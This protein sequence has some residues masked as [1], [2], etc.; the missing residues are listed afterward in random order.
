MLYFCVIIGISGTYKVNLEGRKAGINMHQ[1][2]KNFG[3]VILN[4]V[5]VEKRNMSM[6][7]GKRYI[8]T[9]LTRTPYARNKYEPKDKQEDD[10]Y[11]PMA[12][13]CYVCKQ[14][15]ILP[16]CC[17]LCKG[18][19]FPHCKKLNEADKRRTCG[20]KII[21]E[22]SSLDQDQ[23]ETWRRRGMVHRDI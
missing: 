6:K 17:K 21:T 22:A 9:P 13:D 4:I 3:G 5:W 23:L 10:K 16:F 7:L 1:I 18:H 14:N 2:K 8:W 11:K 20:I 19:H 15:H 12:G